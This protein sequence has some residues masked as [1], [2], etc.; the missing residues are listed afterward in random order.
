MSRRLLLAAI[1]VAA[2]LTALVFFGRPTGVTLVARLAPGGPE[3]TESIDWQVE[4]PSGPTAQESGA[5]HRYHT[6][7]GPLTVTGS[8]DGREVIRSEVRALRGRVEPRIF[9]LD[10]A[11]LRLEVLRD[12]G[13]PL[14]LTVS[15]VEPGFSRTVHP[16]TG[17]RLLLPTGDYRVETAGVSADIALEAGD[18][19]D[20]TLDARDE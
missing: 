5:A 9:T 15:S 18:I 11:L 2:G 3:I 13:D 7:A 20:L 19:R 16:E 12:P 8:L 10:A 4:G 1:L 6:P 14:R 17:T